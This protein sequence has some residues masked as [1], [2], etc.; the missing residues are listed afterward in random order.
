MKKKILVGIMLVLGLFSLVACGGEE[1]TTNST[2]EVQENIDEQT[3]VEEEA[4]LEIYYDA[5]EAINLYLNNYNSINPDT[6]IECVQFFLMK[7]FFF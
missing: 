5:N 4:E 6:M 7:S 1:D 2:D 3:E